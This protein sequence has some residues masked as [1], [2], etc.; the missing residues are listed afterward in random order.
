[1]PFLS[2]PILSSA[3]AARRPRPCPATPSPVGPAVTGGA[4]AV[5]WTHDAKGRS[6]FLFDRKKDTYVDTLPMAQSPQVHTRP[7]EATVLSCKTVATI[8]GTGKCRLSIPTRN[9]QGLGRGQRGADSCKPPPHG[10]WSEKTSC[11]LYQHS[12]QHPQAHTRP[13]KQ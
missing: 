12:A 6:P 11:K 4:K 5:T 8:Q 9:L 1:M 10:Q 7:W 2:C 13:Y 3:T